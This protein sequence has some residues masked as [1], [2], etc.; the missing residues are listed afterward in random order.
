M[1]DYDNLLKDLFI[2][3]QYANQTLSWASTDTLER[4][5]E[6]SESEDSEIVDLVQSYTEDPVTYEFNSYGYRSPEFDE[7]EDG[8]FILVSGCSHTVGIGNRYKDLWWVKLG[9]ALDLP[10]VNLAQESYG[11]DF[12]FY[13]TNIWCNRKYPKPRIAI[14][15]HPVTNRV[16]KCFLGTTIHMFS[17][18]D[19]ITDDN[20]MHNCAFRH[21]MYT[22][23]ITNLWNSQ[24]VPCFHW[25]FQPDADVA[26]MFSTNA[27]Y[28][29]TGGDRA[30][31]DTHDGPGAHTNAFEYLLPLC[32]QTATSKGLLNV[33]NRPDAGLY[34]FKSSNS[35]S[36]FESELADSIKELR[37]N[38]GIIY[39]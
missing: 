36:G 17:D 13:N 34:E 32:K 23:A 25:G 33:M 24:G 26:N 10:V 22:D 35:T 18:T 19:D 6:L 4:F 15:Q 3:P 21:G 31:D 7:V 29:V 11:P 30:R 37:E 16:M 5:A 12:M 20:I 2:N 38:T 14:Y 28:Q 39:D 9:E 1:L 27:I 8:N